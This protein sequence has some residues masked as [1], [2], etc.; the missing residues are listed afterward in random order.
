MTLKMFLPRCHA[1]L[2]VTRG[3]VPGQGR[4]V[5]VEWRDLIVVDVVDFIVVDDVTD[6]EAVGAMTGVT[7]LERDALLRGLLLLLLAFDRVAH[8]VGDL[9][10]GVEHGANGVDL[11]ASEILARLSAD[12]L[13]NCICPLPLER[14]SSLKTALPSFKEM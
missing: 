12:Y 11:L 10:G 13:I 7:R 14:L 5:S 8:P 6:A 2:Q 1:P 3:Q 4:G 9:D